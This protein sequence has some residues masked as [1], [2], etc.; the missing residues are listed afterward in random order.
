MGKRPD[1]QNGEIE[2]Y[3]KTGKTTFKKV[4]ELITE[5]LDI[6]LDIADQV[7]QSEGVMLIVCGHRVELFESSYSDLR[8]LITESLI[9]VRM[10]QRYIPR[11]FFVHTEGSYTTYLYYKLISEG[12]KELVI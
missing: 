11:V 3:N 2:M 8:T 1:K 12:I 9:N 7:Q 6:T 4:R 5:E 10:K